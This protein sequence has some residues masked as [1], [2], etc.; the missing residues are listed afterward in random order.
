MPSKSQQL[1][2]ANC[3]LQ[4][5]N[6]ELKDLDRCAALRVRRICLDNLQF[7]I[8]NL[9]FA[10]L[11]TSGLLSL[12][13]WFLFFYRIADRDLWSSHEGRAAQDAQTILSDHRWG[14]PRL[15]DGKMELQK[16][17]LYYWLV[18]GTAALR[19]GQVDAWSVRLPAAGAAVGCVVVV[20]GLGL[21][22]GRWLAGGIAASMLATALH[23]TWLARI[24]RID[25]P[26]TFAIALALAGF[27]LGRQRG[28]QQSARG[29]WGWFLLAYVAGAVAALLKG[30]IGLILPAGVA[31]AYLLSELRMQSSGVSGSAAPPG[32]WHG[33]RWLRLA[34]ELGLWWGL[35][36]LL[37]LILPWYIWADIQTNGKLVE[38]FFW[39]HNFERGFGGGSLSAHPWWFYGPR[40]AFDLLPWSL[41]LPA[42][43]WL[44]VRRGWWRNDEEVRFGLIWLVAMVC[45]LSCS[46]FKRAD[47]L[48]PAYP[49]AALFLGG[50][51]E[52]CYREF[53]YRRIAAVGFGSILSGVALGWWIYLGSILPREETHQEFRR[54]AE[55][56]RRRAPA[57]ELI[58]FFRTEAHAL[59]F[60][61]GRPIDT[62]LEW[63]NLDI[64]SS[65]PGTYYVVMPPENAQEWPQHLHLG[66]LEEVLR[67]T[68]LSGGSHAHPL[69]L[70]RT[71]PG[72]GP[73]KRP[74]DGGTDS[75]TPSR[76]E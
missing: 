5:A 38:V 20:F 58:L 50:I 25:M 1:Q 7:A 75:K 4:I 31:A 19:G 9:Q 2:I 69:V 74:G 13:C 3:K 44:L 28:R 12:L 37:V 15:F 45:L 26:L 23:Y 54:F 24:G 11:L 36:L 27:Y 76:S 17:P 34:H 49:G 70:L 30:P 65:R 62:I 10:I 41:L 46:R 72:A 52:R 43:A 57:P 53:K 61:V 33:R 6:F 55:E 71:R 29:S 66:Q 47:Y 21:C 67:S 60:H 22:R 18:A 40:L 63:E 64:W 32:R 39:K 59:A 68:D 51:A 42:A 48:L 14:I 56:I 8:C 16:P 73:V 35:P